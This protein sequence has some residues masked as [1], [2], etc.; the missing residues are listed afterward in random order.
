MA[1]PR[2][3][4]PSGAKVGEVVEIKTMI[5]HKMETGLRKDKKGNV[6]PRKIINSFK[7]TFEGKE[8][9]STTIYPS[10]SAN[11]YFAFNFKVPGPGKMVFTWME[12]GNATPITITKNVKTA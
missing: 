5:K 6:I 4:V 10:V 11:P 9:F 8:V 7:V 1:K 3:K 12:D 2:V